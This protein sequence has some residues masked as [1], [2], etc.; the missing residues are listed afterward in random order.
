MKVSFDKE[1]L[2]AAIGP[3]AS[4]SQVK[5]TLT[6]V[7]GLLFECPA[8]EKF[9]KVG[10]EEEGMTRISAFDLEKGLRTTVECRVFEEG[11][12]VINASQIVQIVRVLPDGEITIE[13]DDRNRA[14]ISGGQAS[15]NISVSPADDFPS[16]PMFVGDRRYTLPQFAVREVIGETIF[17]VAQGDPKPALNGGL[18][19]IRDGKLTMVGCDGNRL[20]MAS[21][22]L[23][24]EAPEA[25][26]I[27]PGKF[28]SELSR[29][30]KDSVEET[31]IIIGNKHIIFKIAEIYFFTRLI[32]SEYLNYMR[33]LKTNYNTEAYVDP[34]EFREAIERA[35][36]ISE[37]KLGGN[38][39]SIVKL[40]FSG[41]NIA[42]SCVSSAGSISENVPAAIGGDDIVIGFAGR[43]LL[44]ALK[45]CPD[46]ERLRL[47]MTSNVFGMH[48]ESAE[49]SDFIKYDGEEKRKKKEDD[50]FDFFHLVMPRRINQK[51]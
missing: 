18:M 29:L 36:I 20:A 38:N 27:I 39:K 33:I 28:L 25:E 35:A 8:N 14:T 3:A 4:I 5:N 9:G 15:Y 13:V 48:I 7:E 47:R 44:D 11:M 46:V 32:E 19:K 50:K 42:I 26:V 30:L 22:E 40:E 43:Y 37:D 41:Q 49:G 6:S 23:E 16:M 51:V 34:A 10:E 1:K 17:A 45:A 12:C 21:Y 24:E 2:L 31:T